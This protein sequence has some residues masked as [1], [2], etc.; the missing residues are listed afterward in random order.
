M[1]AGIDPG[2]R[3]GVAI[4]HGVGI[5]DQMVRAFKPSMTHR[6][7]VELLREVLKPEAKVRPVVYVEKVGVHKRDGRKGAN[8]FGRVDGLIRGAVLAWGLELREVA[9]VRWQSELGCLSGGNKNV[10]KR[11]ALEMFPDLR[12]RITHATADALLIAEYGRRAELR[13]NL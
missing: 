1:I 12:A 5:L 7:L 6:E 10:T 3:G 2:V 8:T 4:T 11:K 13:R 9:P